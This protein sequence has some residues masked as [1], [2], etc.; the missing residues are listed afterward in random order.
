MKDLT[1]AIWKDK[2]IDIDILSPSDLEGFVN[3]PLANGE[4]LAESINWE[5]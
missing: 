3:Q 5:N 2:K 4:A 1:T